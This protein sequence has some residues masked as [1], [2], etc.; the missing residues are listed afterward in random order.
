MPVLL[1][2]IS[3]WAQSRNNRSISR[4]DNLVT[5]TDLGSLSATLL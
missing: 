3:L 4:S 1:Y 2:G 5:N